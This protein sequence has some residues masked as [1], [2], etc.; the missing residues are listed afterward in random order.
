MAEL[1]DDIKQTLCT[2]RLTRPPVER[3]YEHE[4][5]LK[6]VVR[7]RAEVR[8]FSL[9]Q[10]PVQVNYERSLRTNYRPQVDR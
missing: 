3:P 2:C 6:F 10:K 4:I 9:E 5:G 8:D 7:E 1:Y